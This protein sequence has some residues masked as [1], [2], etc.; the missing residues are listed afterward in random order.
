MKLLTRS[1]E[2]ALLIVILHSGS[3]WQLAAGRMLEWLSL[4]LDSPGFPPYTVGKKEGQKMYRCEYI[5]MESS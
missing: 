4:C 1:V 5:G 2:P 3:S